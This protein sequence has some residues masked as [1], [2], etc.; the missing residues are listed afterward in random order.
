MA[1]LVRG[2]SYLVNSQ[3]DARTQQSQKANRY[4]N[5][6]LGRSAIAEG[7]HAVKCNADIQRDA[8]SCGEQ[9]EES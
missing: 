6:P 3:T 4:L 7:C 2:I 9:P 5:V 1:H 8:A